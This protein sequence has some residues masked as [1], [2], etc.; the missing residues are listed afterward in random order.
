M[1]PL[2]LPQRSQVSFWVARGTSRFIT[3]HCQQIGVCL[4]F[5]RETHWWQGSRASSQSSTRES[6]LVWCW[7]MELGFPLE[8]SKWCQPSCQVQAGSSVQFSRSVVSD[9]LWP[10]EPQYS[11]HPCPSPTPGVHSDSHPSCQW[12]HP[13]IS[14]SAVPF[15]SCHQSL[16]QHQSIFQWV[17][18][19]H[20]VAKYW[21]FRFSIIPSKEI[22]GLISF[23]MDWLDLLAV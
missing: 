17:N 4:E 22:P 18:S 7:G 15:F 2:E 5:S 16:P 20:E 19:L 23:R 10:H 11:R 8:L 21:S 12:C 14:S 3:S 6:G 9:S 1:E 13:D